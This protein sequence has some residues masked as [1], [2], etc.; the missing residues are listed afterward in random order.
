ML[1]NQQM[2]RAASQADNLAM[3]GYRSG[4]S[5]CPRFT[6]AWPDV[7]AGLSAILLFLF[8]IFPV[9]DIFILLQ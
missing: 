3:R 4:G 1:I 5:L 2:E 6:T 8:G 7:V 9:R